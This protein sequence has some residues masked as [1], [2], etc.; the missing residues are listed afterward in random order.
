MMQHCL[1][2]G[3]IVTLVHVHGHYQCP[4]CCTNALPCC[5]G[6]NCDTNWLPYTQ[7]NDINVS[8]EN[9]QKDTATALITKTKLVVL[10]FLLVSL[11]FTSCSFISADYYLLKAED[12]YDK[13]NYNKA[14]LFTNKAIEKNQNLK[15]AYLLRG[16]CYEEIKRY[17][18]AIKDYKA[19]VKIDPK[20]AFAFYRR[21]ICEYER[22]NYK[23]AITNHNL[24][25]AAKGI[26][27]SDSNENKIYFEMNESIAKSDILYTVEAKEIYYDR[28]L[29]FYLNGQISKAF[30]DFQQCIAQKFNIGESNYMIGLCWLAAED[31]DKACESFKAGQ[32]WGD[33]LSR[34]LLIENCQ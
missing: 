15:N 10:L 21:G 1:F 22:K 12:E 28:G 2:C 20:Y 6:D 16:F 11:L 25:L 24:A 19:V 23:I 33:S 14:I 30:D 34:V 7:P 13:K 31:K 29:S 3:H 5:D 8:T 32:F 18:L 4:V 26:D 27:T 17:D 9:T